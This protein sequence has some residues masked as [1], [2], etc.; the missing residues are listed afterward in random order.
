[1][2]IGDE[3]RY[4]QALGIPVAVAVLA[5]I[6]VFELG[7]VAVVLA[8]VLLVLTVLLSSRRVS[9]RTIRRRLLPAIGLLLLLGG[10]GSLVL[11]TIPLGTF[12]L[13]GTAA[14][15]VRY[16]SGPEAR[17]VASAVAALG[18]LA[19]AAVALYVPKTNGPAIY[20]AIATVGVVLALRHRSQSR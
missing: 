4:P 11:Y 2:S 10:V 20:L 17:H 1:M 6:V 8:S 14:V 5:L 3:I 9:P 16:V 13:G 15:A 19:A 7:T 18:A 12:M